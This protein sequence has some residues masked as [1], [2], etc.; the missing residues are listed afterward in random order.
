MQVSKKSE[1]LRSEMEE[2]VARY[3]AQEE[4]RRQDWNDYLRSQEAELRA[5][6]FSPENLDRLAMVYFGW[7]LGDDRMSPRERIAD[8]IGG[9]PSLADLVMAALRDAI[10]RADVPAPGT[11]LSLYSESRRPWL[12]YPVLASMD[13][14]AGNTQDMDTID[15]ERKRRS[16]AIYYCWGYVHPLPGTAC[17]AA[18][19]RRDPHLVLDVLYRC[20][21]AGLRKGDETPPGIYDLDGLG[22]HVDLAR[23]ARLKLLK[24]FPT[25]IPGKQLRSFDHLLGMALE[26]TS[27]GRLAALAGEKLAKKT[28]SISQAVRW[29][30]VEALLSPGSQSAQRLGSYLNENEQRVRHLGEFLHNTEDDAGGFHRLLSQRCDPTLHIVLVEALGQSY[31]PRT[32]NGLVTA[33]ISTPDFVSKLVDQLG[34]MPVIEAHDGLARLASD[35]RLEAWHSRLTRALERQRVAVPPSRLLR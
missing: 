23:S 34:S 35:P 30:A 21:V 16:L 13:L 7:T 14:H 3:H 29:M 27:T 5:N 8:W 28:L 12:A 19:Y 1:A 33:E 2:R 17:R 32:W 25:R 11:T 26:Q 9:D 31:R 6:R 10:W 24:A 22:D 18:W 15:E 20:A 4:K